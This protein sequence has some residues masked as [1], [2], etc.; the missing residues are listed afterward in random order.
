MADEN[1][2]SSPSAVEE[3]K[4]P[5]VRRPRDMSRLERAFVLFNLV[6]V[7]V[8]LPWAVVGARRM[9]ESPVSPLHLT[10]FVTVHLF[11]TVLFGAA[12]VI[13][14]RDLCLRNYYTT[15]HK[16]MWGLLFFLLW[17]SIY[18][19]FFIHAWKARSRDSE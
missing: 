16:L 13:I 5:S 18:L 2:Y 10:V 11:V 14:V 17:P 1:P 3:A 12:L 6:C 9:E 15:G 19:Y 7:V 4:S 8:Y